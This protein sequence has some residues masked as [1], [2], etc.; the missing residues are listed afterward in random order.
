MNLINP[1]VLDLMKKKPEIRQKVFQEL[2]TIKTAEPA[3]DLRVEMHLVSLLRELCEFAG[4]VANDS[5]HAFN[6]KLSTNDN[7]FIL[8][9]LFQLDFIEPPT[10]GTFENGEVKDIL[11]QQQHFQ[12]TREMLD[13]ACTVSKQASGGKLVPAPSFARW[14]LMHCAD[15]VTMERLVDLLE[16]ASREAILGAEPSVG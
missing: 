12:V 7:M 6:S 16:E 10:I 13:G 4:G 2:Y 15:R 9:D 8:G 1:L 14:L 11:L 5:Q 3:E